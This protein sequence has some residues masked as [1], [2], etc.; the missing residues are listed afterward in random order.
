MAD[1]V[2][3]LLAGLGALTGV[4]RSSPVYALVSAAHVLGIALLIGPILI[5]DLRLM[6]RLAVLNLPA[7]A[8]L[9]RFARLGLALV[10]LTGALLISAKPAEYLANQVVQAKLLVV[11]LAMINAAAFEW[12]VKQLGLA[13][14]VAT[15]R[16]AGIASLCGWVIALLLGRWIAFSQ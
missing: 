2:I 13:A 3:E 6:G 16:L 9:R 4:A 5:V 14:A 12:R 1:M 7:I 10:V 8:V 11:A 15:G